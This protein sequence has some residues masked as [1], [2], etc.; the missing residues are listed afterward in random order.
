MQSGA[1]DGPLQESHT[2]E[3]TMSRAMHNLAETVAKPVAKPGGM[4][5]PVPEFCKGMALVLVGC[6]GTVRDTL[7]AADMATR[8]KPSLT[9]L[10]AATA[11][12]HWRRTGSV[13][14]D[15]NSGALENALSPAVSAGDTMGSPNA[16]PRLN[17]EQEFE[18]QQPTTAGATGTGGAN[19]SADRFE[20]DFRQD[21]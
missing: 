9:P 3:G 1:L 5:R 13:G 8:T 2:V 14:T 10:S 21:K 11:A 4:P 12:S 16:S 17:D 19:D 7:Y 18:Q 15:G 6:T 20:A